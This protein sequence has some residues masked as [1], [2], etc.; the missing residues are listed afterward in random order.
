M[1]YI[2]QADNNQHAQLNKVIFDIKKSILYEYSFD[3]LVF[4]SEN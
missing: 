3:L 2:F 1:H 4:L